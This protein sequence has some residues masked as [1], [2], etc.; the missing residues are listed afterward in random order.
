M[1]SKDNWKLVNADFHPSDEKIIFCS[2]YKSKKG[3]PFNLYMIDI[4]GENLK[5]ITFDQQFDSFP[6][7]SS[8]TNSLI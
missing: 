6:M 2:N 5:Q 7:F 8:L 3:F 1:L 4:N